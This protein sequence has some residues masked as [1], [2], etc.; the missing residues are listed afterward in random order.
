M[1]IP[2]RNDQVNLTAP[3]SKAGRSV[4]P[5]EGSLGDSYITTMRSMAKQFD[6]ISELNFKLSEN[7]V[8]GQLNA[9]DVYVDSRTKQYEKD[10]SLATNQEQIAGLYEQYKKDIAE[11]GTKVLG[12]NLYQNWERVKGGTTLANSE[13]AGA[14]AGTVLQQK[15]NFELLKLSLD[16]RN[17]QAG[18][19][20]TQKE[21]DLIRNQS[22]ELINSS[23]SNFFF[24]FSPSAAVTV[25]FDIL[26]L[27]NS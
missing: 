14:V 25:P 13:Y 16:E 24:N 9:F 20:L 22:Y 4:Q 6:A 17:I 8:R 3:Q 2:Q 15:H 5:V 18:N 7:A 27:I 10:L 12:S 19:A 1:K 26:L 21:Q 23:I 11:N